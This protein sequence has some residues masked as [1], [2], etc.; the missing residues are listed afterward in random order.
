MLVECALKM[1]VILFLRSYF[2]IRTKIKHL[3]Y[4]LC[5]INGQNYLKQG[6][7]KKSIEV[8]LEYDA[9]ERHAQNKGCMNLYRQ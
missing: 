1:A 4:I 7:F 8:R 2:Y 9:S 3:W 6:S 5:H